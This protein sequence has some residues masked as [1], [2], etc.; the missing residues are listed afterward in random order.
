MEVMYIL[1][2]PLG[3]CQQR[4]D[5]GNLGGTFRLLA[6]HFAH[7]WVGF[8]NEGIRRFTYQTHGLIRL[9]PFGVVLLSVGLK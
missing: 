5:F 4:T 6:R 3:L 1:T 9:T 8:D 2:S 7:F